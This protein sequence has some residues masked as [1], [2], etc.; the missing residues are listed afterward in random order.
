MIFVGSGWVCSG[1]FGR[2]VKMLVGEWESVEEFLGMRG[3]PRPGA[4]EREVRV[5]RRSSS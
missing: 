1:S 4:W 2:T 3:V 5:S